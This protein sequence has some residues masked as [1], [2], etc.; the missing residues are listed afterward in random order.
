MN[1]QLKKKQKML[2]QIVIS[3][4]KIPVVF[5]LK[6]LLKEPYRVLF[7]VEMMGVEPMSITSSI[8]TSTSLFC[9]LYSSNLCRQTGL[10]QIYL[11]KIP[12]ITK[13]NSQL[14]FPTVITLYPSRWD[15]LVKRSCNQAANANSSLS[16]FILSFRFFQWPTD[17]TTCYLYF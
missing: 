6:I 15:Y 11:F 17:T 2:F 10:N 5:L 4:K 14:C 13:E 3:G 1:L 7:L 9:L 16:A 12:T 8:Q